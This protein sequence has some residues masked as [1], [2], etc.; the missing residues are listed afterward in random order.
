MLV[1]DLLGFIQTNLDF[2]NDLSARCRLAIPFLD[3]NAPSQANMLVS[4]VSLGL[5]D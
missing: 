2:D 5:M 3:Q 1:L 4:F